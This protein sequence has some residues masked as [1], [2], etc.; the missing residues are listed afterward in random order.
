[1]SCRDCRISMFWCKQCFTSAAFQYL[2]FLALNICFRWHLLLQ[3]G[4]SCIL[5]NEATKLVHLF[6]VHSAPFLDFVWKTV[7]IYQ[8][9]FIWAHFFFSYYEFIDLCIYNKVKNA[10]GHLW[11]HFNAIIAKSTSVHFLEKGL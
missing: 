2:C 9:F 1:M 11:M 7:I 5:H 3:C 6:L 10:G 4:Q 8:T